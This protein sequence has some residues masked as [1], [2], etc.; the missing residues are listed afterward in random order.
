MNAPTAA[1]PVLIT[2]LWPRRHRGAL[3]DS[4]LALGGSLALWA[5]A[6]MQVPFYPVP[7]TL[8]TLVLLVIGMVYGWRLGM[9]TVALYLAA[10]AAGL[11]VFAG[12]PEKGLGLFYMTGP[13]GGYL[14]GFVLA[15]GVCGYLAER[16]WDRR[17]V[18][19]MLAMVAGN[20]LIYLPGLLWLGW[21]LGWVGKRH[22]RQGT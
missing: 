11:P 1:M 4:L 13:T 14:L 19:V 7:M 6:K 5:S 21:L 3:R 8:Q 16:G 10:G 9:A 22:E 12:T 20:A 17:A 2:L 18:T 15:V